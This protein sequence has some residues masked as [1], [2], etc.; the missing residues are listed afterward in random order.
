MAIKDYEFRIFG[1]ATSGV[2]HTIASSNLRTAPTVLGQSV[3]VLKGRTQSRPW[4]VEINDDGDFFSSI[5]ADAGG[6]MAIQGRLCDVRLNKDGAGFSVIGTGRIGDIVD[7][8]SHYQVSVQDERW[9]ERTARVFTKQ[10]VAR[11]GE[12]VKLGDG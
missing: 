5:I 1:A 12:E 11:G 6:R 2:E 8:V 9:K 7:H 10:N 3:D 4:D